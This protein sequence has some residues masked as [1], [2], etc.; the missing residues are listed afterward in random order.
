VWSRRWTTPGK[1][2][3]ETAH[4]LDC[5]V[6]CECPILKHQGREGDRDSTGILENN[7]ASGYGFSEAPGKGDGGLE[8]KIKEVRS[9][10]PWYVA[11]DQG[12]WLKHS[13]P[14]PLFFLF[15]D[16]K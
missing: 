10:R 12:L 14:W 16:G 4:I 2:I 3:G 6:R 1:L 8:M 13:E 15:R 9:Q 11:S 5:L 7:Q